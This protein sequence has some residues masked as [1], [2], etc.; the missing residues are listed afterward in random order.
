MDSSTHWR[1][2]CLIRAKKRWPQ[3]PSAPQNVPSLEET[4]VSDKVVSFLAGRGGLYL[5]ARY[6]V[7][8]LISVANMFVLTWLIGPHNYGLFVTAI[9]IT[10]VLASLVRSGMDTCVVRCEHTSVREEYDTAWTAI[11]AFSSCAMVIGAAV[12]PLLTWWL[13]SDEFVVAY[14]VTLLTVPLA[15]L[16]G[17]A[18]AKLE[19]ALE[20][21]AVATIEL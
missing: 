3:L 10:S 21:R 1:E 20:F 4:Q 17:P 18:T 13:H 9:S 7:G 16:A 12:L 19:R 15:G 6:A 14:L 5:S 11:A 2:C 8:V